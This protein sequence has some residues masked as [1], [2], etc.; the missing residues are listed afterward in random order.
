MSELNTRVRMRVRASSL[1]SVPVDDTL[2]ISGQA[3]DAKATGDALALKAD[4]SQ[5]T[6]IKVNGQSADQQGLIYID[7]SDIPVSDSDS[8]KLDAAI[9]ALQAKNATNIPMSGESGA[10]SIADV[11]N[12]TVNRDASTIPLGD[13]TETTVKGAIE[14]AQEDVE[15]LQEDVEAIQAWTAADVPFTSGTGAPTTKGKID[16][17][18]TDVEAIKAWDADDIPYESGGE[19]SIKDKIDDL[20]DGRVK[21]VNG[22]EPN[23]AGNIQISTVPYADDLTTDDNVQVDAPFIV[24][25]AGGRASINSG[26]AWIR[27]LKGNCVHTGFVAEVLEMDVENASREDPADE[28][29]AELNRATFKAYVDESGTIT[30]MYNSGWKLNGEAVDIASYGITVTGTAIAGDMIVIHY[31]KEERG[32]ITPADPESLVS[33]GWN[34]FNSNAGY[35]RVAA[36]EGL[37][38]VGGTYS[39][40]R[41]AKTPGGT[42]SPIVV[43]GNG[44]FEIEEDGYVLLTGGNGTNTYIICCWS[45]WEGGYAGAFKAYEESEIDLSAIMESL[46]YGLCS[47]G[48]VYDEINFNTKQIIPRVSRIAYSAE[49][50]ADAESSGRAYDFDEDYIYLEM[51]AQEIAAGTS[52]FALENQYEANEHGLEFFPGTY[53]PVGSEIAYGASLKDK[54]RRDVLTIS[55]QTLNADQKTQVLANIGASAAIKTADDAIRAIL[56]TMFKKVTYSYKYA[57]IA[58]SGTLAITANNLAKVTPTGYTVVGIVYYNSGYSKVV[59]YTINPV[60]EGDNTLVTLLNTS[61]SAQANKT[62]K[63]TILYAKTSLL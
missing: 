23:A 8:T 35:A 62:F 38:K 31:V 50:R 18:D 24:R 5:V 41:F 37:Y 26:H 45:D 14:D 4:L 27:R 51:T 11:I 15:G 48:N 17:L 13:G 53:A 30:L 60:A 20:N 32:T 42:S 12:S 61:T 43:D 25:T 44:L 33:T 34:L 19:D 57:S 52:S 58:A 56:K 63:I 47:V 49:A 40:I 36:Y 9:A 46:P 10:Q 39:T 7:G 2:S 16:S 3:A 22:E 59:P 6:G 21:T 54:L 29:T 28:I 1:Q 55:Q